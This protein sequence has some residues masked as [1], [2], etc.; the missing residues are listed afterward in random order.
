MIA[1]LSRSTGIHVLASAGGEQFAGEYVQLG[2]ALFT[3]VLLDAL[4]GKADG[5]SKD[6][7]ITIYEI[8]SYLDDQVPEKSIELKGKPQYPYSFS[9]GHDFPI[10]VVK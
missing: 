1:Q 8:K 6:G 7:K 5:G 10:G 4:E 2:H 3:Y 9:R